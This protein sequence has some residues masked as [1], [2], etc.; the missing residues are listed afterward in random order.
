M[1]AATETENYFH[2]HYDDD[3]DEEDQEDVDS[4]MERVKATNVIQHLVNNVLNLEVDDW[5]AVAFPRGWYPGQFIRYDDESKEVFVNFLERTSSNSKSFI[6]PALNSKEEDKS[7][8]DE[9]MEVSHNYI[10]QSF[11]NRF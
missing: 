4:A 2:A 10:L 11:Y 1:V 3:E 9:G 8:V 6:W 7:W 5:V